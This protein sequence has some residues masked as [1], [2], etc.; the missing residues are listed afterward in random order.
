MKFAVQIALLTLSV[1]FWITS[2]ALILS[3]VTFS[4]KGHIILGLA[5]TSMLVASALFAAVDFVKEQRV[6][7]DAKSLILIS[8]LLAFSAW[9]SYFGSINE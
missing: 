1:A 2:S 6:S 7:S 4:S 5:M 3:I 9:I 8:T